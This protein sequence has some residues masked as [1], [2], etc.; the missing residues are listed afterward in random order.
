MNRQPPKRPKRRNGCD[1]DFHAARGAREIAGC[2]AKSLLTVRGYIAGPVASALA[3]TDVLERPAGILVINMGAQSTGFVLF[4]RGIPV[5]ADCIASGGQ[6]ISEEIVRA[7]T[8][9]NSKRN[10]SKSAMAAC[11]IACKLISICL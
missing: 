1:C 6:Q 5:F 11:T 3:V 7:F 4:S 10:A 9:A 2:L 8:F